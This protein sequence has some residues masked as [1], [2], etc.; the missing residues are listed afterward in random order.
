MSADWL[1]G[2]V[3]GMWIAIGLRDFGGYMRKRRNEKP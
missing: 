1:Y 2:I 3:T